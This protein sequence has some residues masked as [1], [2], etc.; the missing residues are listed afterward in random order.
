MYEADIVS[1]YAVIKFFLDDE[2]LK[3]SQ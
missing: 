1:Y 3:S 2:K